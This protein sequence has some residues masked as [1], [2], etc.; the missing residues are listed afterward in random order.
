M[1]IEKNLRLRRGDVDKRLTSI[2]IVCLVVIA[3]FVGFITFESD[4][5][6]AA[7][8]YVGSGAGNHTA[9]I[10]DAIDN[11]ANDGDTVFVYGGRYFEN[12]IVN[13]TINLTGEDWENTIIDGGGVGDAVLIKRD[14]VNV[15]GFTFTNAQT[16]IELLAVQDCRVFN[17]LVFTNDNHGI[18]LSNSRG[19]NI[20]GNTAL[21]NHVGIALDGSFWE[22]F[23]NNITGNYVFNNNYGI[24]LNWASWNNITDNNVSDNEDGI[25]LY[26][27]S[28]NIIQNNNVSFNDKVGIYLYGSVGNTLEGNTMINNG[29]WIGG[30]VVEHWNTHNIDTS[31][32]V[33]SKPVQYWKNRTG[34]KVPSGAGEVILANCTN[35]RVEGQE[36]THGTVG[37]ELGFSSNNSITG[38]DVSSN[39]YFGIYLFISNGNNIIG[40]NASLSNSGI[41]IHYSNEN[42]IINNMAFSNIIAGIYLFYSSANQIIGNTLSSNVW[43]GIFLRA[44][45]S[46]NTIYHNNF[47]NNTIQA[48]DDTNN[49]NQWNNGYP[50]GGNYWSDFDEPSEGAYDD[51][52]GPN[53]DDPTSGDGIVDNGTIAGGGK[54]PYII[55]PDSQDDYPLT[56]YVDTTPPTITNL[57]PPDGS[58]TS[59]NTPI[60]SAD[61]GDP[62]GI[63]VSSVVLKVDGI[64]VTFSATVTASGV[65]YVPITALPDGIHTV[66][67]EVKDNYGNLATTTWS[68]TVDTALPPVTNLTTKVVNNGKNVELEWDPPSSL[69]LDHYLIYRADSA[70]GFDF[71]IPYNS[72][73]TWMDPKNTIWVDPDP[74]VTAVD[75]DFYYIVRAANFDESDVS[76]TSNTAGVWTRT[77]QAGISTFSLPLEPFVKKDTEF[78]CQDM[79]ASYIKWMNLTTHTWMRHDRGSSENNSIIEIGKGYEIGFLGKSI[80]T[81][82]TFTGMSGAMILYDDVPF[83]FDATPL[84]G[85]AN[86]LS[87]TVDSGGNVTLNWTQP[88][89]MG[90]GDQYYVLRSTSRDGFWGTEGMNYTQLAVLP[91][92]IL[93]YQD[94]G[95]AT[96]STEYYYMIVP[97]N[98]STGKRGV[99][100]YSIGVWTAGY[101]DQY[102]TF[103]IPLKP[104]NYQTADWFCDNIP[105]TVGINYY[106]YSQQRWGWHSTRMPAGAYDPVL[107]MTEGYQISTSS[108]TK[109]T[110]IGK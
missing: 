93:S 16:G 39:K 85:N 17:N 69:A 101:L 99:S 43:F 72:S 89:N 90:S 10:Q 20:T 81:S 2:G 109:F 80:Q 12:V 8:I 24:S 9:S 19:N 15:S 60:I 31:N 94:I 68:F 103:G 26:S 73:T 23:G 66:Y 63:N 100:S 5:V 95:N 36:L 75:D 98:L 54:N 92:D 106:I 105:D 78:Y 82:Y 57:Q 35:V 65:S 87:A 104:S 64:D 108:A 25:I 62:S 58:I 71:S 83:G 21:N 44:T 76:L 102:D 70:T 48:R 97:V 14:W 50:S 49:G 46:N 4:V 18:Y 91:F 59:D 3:T 1:N 22:N 27:S 110:F 38:N 61:Y 51:Y 29:I 45:A 33:N 52:Q 79:N 47:V 32:T 53:Q 56:N 77:F 86:N 37:I 107:E 84:A 67:L 40:N 96:A 11:Y 34:G 13:K 88:T 30:D 28:N 7:T 74:N 6:S 55:D 42:N 41:S